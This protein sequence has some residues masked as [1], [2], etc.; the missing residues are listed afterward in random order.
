MERRLGE[1][2]VLYAL[3]PR[4]AELEEAVA[5]IGRWGAP[6][7]APGRGE[8]AFRPRWL[9]PALPAVLRG[10]TA[11]PPVEVGV[12]VDGLRLLLRLDADGPSTRLLGDEDPPVVLTTD[13]ETLLGLAAGTLPVDRVLD[14]GALRG[15]PEVLGR[16]FPDPGS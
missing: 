1:E 3:T 9:L 2:G 5:A 14:S 15:D 7:L 4:G 13:A 10:R 16:V 11:E 6:L 12:V 8:D